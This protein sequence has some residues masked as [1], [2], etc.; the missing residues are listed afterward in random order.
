MENKEIVRDLI[1]IAKELVGATEYPDYDSTEYEVYRRF[2]NSVRK[3]F[4]KSGSRIE[5]Y[6]DTDLY[7]AGSPQGTLNI[8]AT[9]ALSGKDLDNFASELDEAVKYIKGKEK[10]AQKLYDKVLKKKK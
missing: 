7:N 3:T 9:G 5:S 1:K 2:I 8:S 4:S 10:E 6:V